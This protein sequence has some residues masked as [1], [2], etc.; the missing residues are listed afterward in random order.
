MLDAMRQDI[1]ERMEWRRTAEGYRATL[2]LVVVEQ[3][4]LVVA[5][6]AHKSFDR[7]DRTIHV[8]VPNL[9]FGL[10]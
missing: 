5:D 4:E 6:L 2:L 3:V 7:T 9:A 10:H 8:I 1:T